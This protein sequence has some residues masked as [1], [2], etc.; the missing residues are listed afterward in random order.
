[1]PPD[2]LAAPPPAGMRWSEDGPCS[3]ALRPT[4]GVVVLWVF[5]AVLSLGIFVGGV[6][7]YAEH[8]WKPAVFEL[9]FLLQ[10]ARVVFEVT[11]IRFVHGQLTIDRS[12]TPLS[13]IHVPMTDIATFDVAER[14]DGTFR[15]VV[16]SKLGMERVLPISFDG[17]T[18]TV[19]MRRKRHFASPISYAS[20]AA[21]RLT[22]MLEA[23]KR[24][25]EHSWRPGP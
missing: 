7:S 16:R 8:P 9:V 22:L 18:L 3:A 11:R 24:R 13:G 15:V 12:F 14:D 20:Y 17:L 19:G 6:G 21:L 25:A 4:L 1:M 5:S 10:C 23:A 2:A